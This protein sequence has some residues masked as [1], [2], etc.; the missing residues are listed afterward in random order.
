MAVKKKN[1]KSP[2]KRNERFLTIRGSKVKVVD[3]LPDGWKEDKR[4]TTAPKGYVWVTNNKSR[5]GGERKA[6]LMKIP[7]RS[8]P[9][10]S[11]KAP[12]KTAAKPAA[13]TTTA[14]PKKVVEKPA[15]K[16]VEPKPAAPKNEPTSVKKYGYGGTFREKVLNRATTNGYGRDKAEK[17][18]A[19]YEG[20]ALYICGYGKADAA[21]V[22]V[23]C[24]DADLAGFE[25][26]QQDKLR[27]TKR[28]SP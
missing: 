21:R 6:A 7:T 11:A 19:Y 9:L 8:G 17:C 26:E 27:K 22:A 4:A 2:Q 12:K 20:Y 15:V 1:D 18:L 25:F 24:L 13:K 5:F 16:R 14:Q 3:S 28:K 23:E 10:A